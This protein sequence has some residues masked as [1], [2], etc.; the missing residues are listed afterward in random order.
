MSSSDSESDIQEREVSAQRQK[1]TITPAQKKALEKARLAK[2][3]KKHQKMNSGSSTS[4]TVAYL[5]GLI[6]LSAGVWG[7]YYYTKSQEKQKSLQTKLKE[8]EK[9]AEEPKTIIKKVIQPLDD[10]KT[11]ISDWIQEALSNQLPDLEKK[12]IEQVKPVEPEPEPTP[13]PEPEENE[14][15]VLSAGNKF[16]RFAQ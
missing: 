4:S 16:S 6:L 15:P 1:K 7:A 3:M 8:A 11:N 10:V 9:K 2:A 12:I 5:S 14:L 13:E